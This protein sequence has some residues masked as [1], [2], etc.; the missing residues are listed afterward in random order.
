[1]GIKEQL[2]KWVAGEP[3]HNQE[4]DEC[5]PDF[6]C[7]NGHIAPIS[8]RKRFLQAYQEN[9]KET[10]HKMLVMFLGKAFSEVYVIDEANHTRVQ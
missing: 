6:S 9:D 2:E 7:C 4:R 3:I 1:M 8:E 10:M 5:C